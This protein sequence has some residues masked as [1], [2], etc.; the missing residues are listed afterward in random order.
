MRIPTEVLEPAGS[1]KLLPG[2]FQFAS[3]RMAPPKHLICGAGQGEATLSAQTAPS[4]PGTKT[5]HDTWR[6]TTTRLSKASR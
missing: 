4:G 6:S 2:L 1:G 3:F 5:S